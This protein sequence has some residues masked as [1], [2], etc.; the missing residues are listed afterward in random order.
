[1]DYFY[2][3]QE[4]VLKGKSYYLFTNINVIELFSINFQVF[5]EDELLSQILSTVETPSTPG[6]HEN[7]SPFGKVRSNSIF[8]KQHTLY[9]IF[10]QHCTLYFI[11]MKQYALYC[12]FYETIHIVSHFFKTMYIVFHFYETLYIVLDFYETIYIVSHFYETIYM[13]GLLVSNGIRLSRIQ[14]Y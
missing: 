8:M 9:W 1:M 5:L 6:P 4:N 12:I 11:F 10:I 13:F 2:L 7:E 14:N 3:F